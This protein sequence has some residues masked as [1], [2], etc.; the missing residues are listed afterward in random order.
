MSAPAERL[1]VVFFGHGSPMIALE[2]NATTEAWAQIGASIGKPRGIVCI[3]AHWLT[4]GVAVTAMTRPPTIH[5]FGASFPQA[6]FDVQY[7]APGDPGLAREVA[8]LL[9][10]LPVT[11]DQSWGLDH[12]TWSVLCKA[13]PQADVPV[14]QLSMDASQPPAWHFEIG[15]RL[16]PLRE[17]GVLIIGTG[18]IV[19]NLPA[20]DWGARHRPAYD[21]AKA[22]NDHVTGAIAADEP[23]KVIAFERQGEAAAR[24]VPTP[25]HYWPL[26]Y[27]LGAR[28]PGDRAV[29]GPDHIEHGS[30]SM[31]T[32]MLDSRPPAAKAA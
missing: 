24:S 3:S 25:D 11:Q 26:L 28:L 4:R 12:G 32:V 7:P 19:H 6:L 29:F 10:P 13:Y 23:G 22:F 2:T 14:V 18:N 15:R 5:D 31:T 1:P 17:A 8:D 9:A 30:L 27:V 16:A 21:W 20:M